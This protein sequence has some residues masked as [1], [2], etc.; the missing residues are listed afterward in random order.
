MR[1]CVNDLIITYIF[2]YSNSSIPEKCDIFKQKKEKKRIRRNS[3][4]CFCYKLLLICIN[5]FVLRKYKTKRQGKE[6]VSKIIPQRKEKELYD[7][8][9]NRQSFAIT[10]NDKRLIF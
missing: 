6:I 10:G 3:D 9:P 2:S 7:V 1:C 8:F 5:W 4:L